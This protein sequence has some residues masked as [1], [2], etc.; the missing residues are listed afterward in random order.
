MEAKLEH[1]YVTGLQQRGAVPS[2]IASVGDATSSL[3]H[4]RFE[5]N[6]E[7]STA[8]Q[9]LVVQSQP[10]EIIYDA[11]SISGNAPQPS[12]NCIFICNM[13]LY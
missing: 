13:L 5:T 1:W 11:V 10:V 7:G 12:P 9:L 3:L 6:P 4:I 2:L 8:D